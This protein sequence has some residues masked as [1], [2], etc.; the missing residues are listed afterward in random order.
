[1]EFVLLESVPDA[2]VI[3]EHGGRIAYVNRVAEQLF[4][5]SREE[6]VGDSVEALLPASAQE[7]HR[8]H[9][10]GYELAPRAR[11]M[12]S[13]IELTG[14]RKDGTEFAAEISLA[15][16][17]ADGRKYVIAAVRDLTERKRIDERAQ[18]WR[19]AQTE[20][21]RRD[22]FLSIAS[23]NLRSPVT[24]L[25]LHLQMLQRLIDQ[26][27][28]DV[29]AAVLQKMS[30]LERQT[31][32]LA[33]L[34]NEL[35]DVSRLR[36]GRLELAL[37]EVDLA[38]LVEQAVDDF[39]D[40]LD[41]ASSA[42][43]IRADVPVEGRWDRIRIEQVVITLVA[44]AVRCAGGRPITMSVEQVDGDRARIAIR[45]QGIGSVARVLDPLER[46]GAADPFPDR[47]LGLFL[48]REIVR[49]HGGTISI[50]SEPDTGAAL[51]LELPRAP[52]LAA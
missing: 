40:E 25:Q 29:T 44:S 39:R 46:A 28:A 27:D 20:L 21:E 30:V 8:G 51:T 50:R 41:L 3:V 43:V 24:S 15:P 11:P 47:G 23:Q 17:S 1:M 5:Y 22:E 16:M 26:P 42:I 14:S 18:L 49:A 37:E 10:Q 52:P 2:V 4:G 38:R 45:G 48:A 13:G 32:R 9:R 6:L 33:R 35:L 12:G 34:V 7:L 31:R 36:L 19:E